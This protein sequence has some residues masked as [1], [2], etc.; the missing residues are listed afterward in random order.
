[1]QIRLVFKRELPFLA[2][3]LAQMALEIEAKTV[4]FRCENYLILWLVWLDALS[5]NILVK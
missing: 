4:K 5:V 3:F 2:P 1:M